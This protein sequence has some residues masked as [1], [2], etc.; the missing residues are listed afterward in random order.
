MPTSPSDPTPSSLA[1]KHVLVVED[2]EAT[3]E[4]F[5]LILSSVGYRV[6]TADNGQLALDCLRTER[7]SVILLDLMM[8]EVSGFNVIDALQRD[9]GTADIPVIVVTA[10]AITP[11]DRA[12]L[13]NAN[14]PSI[15]IVDKAGFDRA[16]FLT[17]VRRAL[18][19]VEKGVTSA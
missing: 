1:P 2:N 8:P 14:H 6:S 12:S 11:E 18:V 15:R 4:A 13:G 3:R 16:R 5:A 17:E 19:G 9:P 7:P 10:K